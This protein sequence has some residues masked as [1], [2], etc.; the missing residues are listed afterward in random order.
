MGVYAYCVVPAAHAPVRQTGVAGEAVELIEEDGV[1]I[2]IGR[3]PRPEASVE[4]V[5]AHNRIVEAA[6][7]EQVTPVPLRFG[8]WLED[9]PSLRA[10]MR[11]KT[12]WYRAR[13]AEFEGVL[14][15]G[16]RVID[17]SAEAE[18]RDVRPAGNP[19]GREYMQALR[20]NSRLAEQRQ[21]NANRVRARI[22]ELMKDLVRA[23][24]ED[25]TRT[26]HAVLTIMHLVARPDFDEYRERAR[27]LRELFPE[28][29][30]LVS[31]PWPPYSF[32]I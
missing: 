24:R 32:A 27:Q 14:E 9:E 21:A 20:D 7:T 31:G 29:R 30:W 18:A 22:Q 5:Q 15:F 25:E 6:I 1:G 17:P 16:L 10:A 28:L 12:A 23:E 4:T 13:L 2:W 26:P 11:E 3:M 8:Q 19:S